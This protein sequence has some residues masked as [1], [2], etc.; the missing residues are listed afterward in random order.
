MQLRATSFTLDGEEVV[1]GPD[2]VAIFDALHRR[3]TVSEA[4]LYAFDLLELYGED[5]RGVP[6][7]DRKKRLASWWASAAS[8]LFVSWLG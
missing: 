8:S 4:M 1:C 5:L 7:R 6:L 3:R 2:G